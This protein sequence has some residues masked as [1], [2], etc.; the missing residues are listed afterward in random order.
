MN[1]YIHVYIHLWGYPFSTAS[2]WFWNWRLFSPLV[3]ASIPSGLLSF[4]W[5]VLFLCPFGDVSPL[6]MQ[7]E[8]SPRQSNMMCSFAKP[9]IYTQENFSRVQIMR[10]KEYGKT[11]WND[12][13]WWDTIFHGGQM[14]SRDVKSFSTVGSPPCPSSRHPSISH[15]GKWFTTMGNGFPPWKTISYCFPYSF[16]R[17]F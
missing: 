4:C 1:I 10:S 11:M 6:G 16:N 7:G 15:C 9:A 13:Q 12:V 17:L 14:I 3:T 8:Q 5:S 2:Q